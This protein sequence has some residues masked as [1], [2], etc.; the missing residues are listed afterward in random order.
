MKKIDWF[1]VSFFEDKE[2]RVNPLL[3]KKTTTLRNMIKNYLT[4]EQ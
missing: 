1:E 2:N 3:E 4:W